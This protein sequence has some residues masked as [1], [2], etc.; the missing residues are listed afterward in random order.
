MSLGSSLKRPQQH[1]E[2]DNEQA[3]ACLVG[4]CHDP[5]VPPGARRLEYVRRQT[6]DLSHRM[7]G[8]CHDMAGR[9]DD[10]D[11]RPFVISEADIRLP[12]GGRDVEHGNGL[13]SPGHN[14]WN[15]GPRP[16]N[17]NP[18]LRVQDVLYLVGWN[19]KPGRVD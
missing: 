8:H 4:L 7:N 2:V 9:L 1:R 16:G 15:L 17:W 14:T 10:D 3:A 6:A 11:A 5:V 13:S 19:P 18:E 12:R